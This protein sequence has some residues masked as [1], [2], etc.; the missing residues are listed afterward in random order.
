MHSKPIQHCNQCGAPVTYRVPESDT[1]ARAVCPVCGH[2]QYENPRNIVGTVPVWE[3][4]VLLCRRAIEPRH[5]L[6]TLPAGFMELN[7]TTEQGAL[8]ETR[9]EAGIE[10]ELDGLYCVANV[11]PVSQVYLLYRARM[12]HAH[13]APGPETL[14]AQLFSREDVPW[15]ELAF[16]TVRETLHRFFA[17]QQ[18][19][20]YSLQVF[21]ID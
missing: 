2:I 4:R 21:D 6:W 1:H 3:G 12:L 9:E 18:T 7:E 5:G 17:E 8:R 14:E 11:K 15:D 16:R 10:V 20:H 13:W 19:G